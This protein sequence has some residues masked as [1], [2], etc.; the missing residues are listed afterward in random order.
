MVPVMAGVALLAAAAAEVG[1]RKGAE[2][3][4]FLDQ[5][6]IRISTL[7]PRV[8][9]HVSAL[10]EESDSLNPALLAEKVADAFG[11][12]SA[13]ERSQLLAIR[14][15]LQADSITM[16][17]PAG[18]GQGRTSR[19]SFRHPRIVLDA[20][21]GGY[22]SGSVGH[23]GLKEKDFTLQIARRLGALLS[24]RLGAQ[25]IFTRSGDLSVPLAERA[26]IANQADA[27]LLISI[28]ANS[29]DDPLARGVET[30]VVGGYPSA[31]ATGG[32]LKPVAEPGNLGHSRALAA[33][34]QRE[35]FHAM[36]ERNE[37]MNRGVKEA[38]FVVLLGAE[39]PAVLAEVAFLTNPGDEHRLS[40]PEGQEAVAD[41]LC[42][43]VANYLAAARQNKTVAAKGR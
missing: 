9:T 37:V 22:D 38:P 11:A 15:W 41:A 16:F 21:H 29:S 31:A 40:T 7:A 1:L 34:V 2:V 13:A 18:H 28:H 39:M 5:I 36:G 30:Y 43:G 24:S 8:D 10:A 25:V 14:T 33:E 17:P 26:A 6:Q 35:L 4:E 20:G 3:R 32:A 23:G 42:R 12:W 27:D 19:A